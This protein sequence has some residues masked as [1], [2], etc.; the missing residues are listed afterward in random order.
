M[1][2]HDRY[3]IRGLDGAVEIVRD[4]L[5]VPHCSA[6]SEHDAFFAQGW[7][8]ATDRLFQLEYDRRRALGRWA[9]VVG[10][11]AVA[12]DRFHRQMDHGWFARRDTAALGPDAGAMLAAYSD[13]INA[14]LRSGAATSGSLDAAGV[15]PEPWEPWHCVAVHRVRHVLMGSARP[16]LWRD[17]LT[18][19]LGAE[20]AAA[21]LAASAKGHVAS[22]PPGAPCPP[23]WWSDGGA[24]GGSNSWALTG[25]RTA[26]GRPLLAG[27]PH[28]ELEVP[29]VYAQGHLRCDKWDALGIGIPGVPGFSHFGHNATVAW[30]ITHG[31]V[32]DQDLYR[33]AAPPAAHRRIERIEVRGGD[34]VEV[35]VARTE[36][37]ML[38][39]PRLA[40]Q[41]TATAAPNTGFDAIPAML[42]A[43]S[44]DDLFEAM[45][46]WAE[47]ANNLLAADTGGHI[48][49][50][51][52]G[53]VPRR[54]R[55]EATGQIV[56]GDDPSFGWDG[57]LP[58]EDHPRLVDPAEGWLF[59]ANNPPVTHG[60]YLG[61]DV[62]TPWR[63]RRLIDTL[64]SLQK[65][66][67]GNMAVVHRDRVSLPA[68]WWQE[69]LAGWAP[70]TGWDGTL[71]PDSTAAAAYEVFRRQL[72]LLCLERSGLAAEAAEFPN[73][74]LPGIFPEA[75][76]WAAAHDLARAD[77]PGLLGG[78]TW[79]EAIAEAV[80]RAEAAW[81]GSPW[82][83]LHAVA[84]RHPLGA[85][86][87]DPPAVAYGGDADTVQASG[88]LVTAGGITEGLRSRTGSVAR[89]VFD[90]ADWDQSL[91]VLPL[92]A[93][94]EPDGPHFADQQAAWAEGRLFPAPYSPAAVDASATARLTLLPEESPE[95]G[96]QSS[97]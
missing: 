47:P 90:P 80:R 28:R 48:G 6:A 53:R 37:G 70:L 67:R 45:R 39:E 82:G 13:G 93:D 62:A 50:L 71:R 79:D 19:V 64:S 59:S 36:R 61:R 44:V 74:L 1:A 97:S 27:D 75:A 4:A 31:M 20:A 32:D 76:V 94:G 24:D 8:H 85:Q 7:C 15:T 56:D 18:R 26:S 21:V 43:E 81:D 51:L 78:W 57:F 69:R 89:Y 66:T 96:S 30:C 84:P 68:R 3:R 35:E 10:P 73:R 87:A 40:L 52:R 92:G 46:P 5:G 91:W 83:R 23:D 55:M 9:E 17:L 16:K 54:R 41:W 65:A 25:S 34:P 60:P 38:L 29:N 33:F 11:G 12:A 77:N 2:G 14:A 22:A 72:A 86:G 58:F 63:S 88:A 95:A 42:G 49:Y